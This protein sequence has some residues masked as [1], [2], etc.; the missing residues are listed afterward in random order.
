MTLT[1]LWPWFGWPPTWSS[2]GTMRGQP[3][4]TSHS[5]RENS[6]L[7]QYLANRE[8]CESSFLPSTP[9]EVPEW[10]VGV[11]WVVIRS[12][13]PGLFDLKI[14][15]DV[16]KAF[17]TEAALTVSQPDFLSFYTASKKEFIRLYDLFFFPH[18]LS[19]NNFIFRR[20]FSALA[21][22]ATKMRTSVRA[23]TLGGSDF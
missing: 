2:P 8:A 10:G 5:G 3:A 7:R 16:A 21:R 23:Q 22:S 20:L 15:C 1:G 12:I 18:A 19:T 13:K 4:S 17:L 6:P 14:S 11:V 9:F